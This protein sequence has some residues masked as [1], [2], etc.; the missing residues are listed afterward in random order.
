MG[1]HPIRLPSFTTE[2]VQSLS[3]MYPNELILVDGVLKLVNSDGTKY[4]DISIYNILGANMID[5]SDADMYEYNDGDYHILGVYKNMKKGDIVSY[6]N[7]YYIIKDIDIDLD[8]MYLGKIDFNVGSNSNRRIFST[9]KFNS[10][11]NT[12]DGYRYSSTAYEHD[13]KIGDIVIDTNI[14]ETPVLMIC[15]NST[16][17]DETSE[18]IGLYSPLTTANQVVEMF[19]KQ[20]YYG[21]TN[22]IPTDER[23]FTLDR[24]GA[25][26]LTDEAKSDETLTEII[27]PYKYNGNLISSIGSFEGN[28]IV[29]KMVLPNNIYRAM[30]FANCT[31][32]SSINIDGFN[33][34][35][36]AISLFENCKLS[37][38][39]IPD[40]IWAISDR[41]FY[42]CKRMYS[43]TLPNGLS[44]IGESA[45][46]NC[47]NLSYITIPSS[48]K[49]I[50]PNAF[51]GCTDLTIFCE[52]G[53]YVEKYAIE[54]GIPYDLDL[55]REDTCIERLQ[56]YGDASII[57]SPDSYFVFGEPDEE[58][59]TIA[60]TSL[61]LEGCMYG[62]NN[63]DIDMILNGEK[64]LKIVVPYQYNGYT[65]TQL[66]LYLSDG[67]DSGDEG[68]WDNNYNISNIIIPNTV[69]KIQ[70]NAFNNNSNLRNITL[71]DSI[72]EI[73]EYAFAYCS[74]LNSV[75][76]SKNITSLSAGLFYE[77]KSIRL[78]KIPE[79]VESISYDTFGEWSREETSKIIIPDSVTTIDWD[80]V[81]IDDGDINKNVI[82]VCNQGSY[83][84]TYAK[85]KRVKYLYNEISLEEF[86]SKN[87]ELFERLKYY[88]DASIVP[89]PDTYFSFGDP[90]YKN[91]SIYI[92]G[93]SSEVMES[94]EAI[95]EE[96]IIPYKYTFEG[97]DFLV[98]EVSLSWSNC[99]EDD[100]VIGYYSNE[101]I[102]KVI[103]PST[104][105]KISENAFNN[106]IN[107]E[108]INIPDSVIEIGECAFECCSNLKHIKLSKN[109]TFISR[110]LFG[111]CSSIRYLEIPEGV[112][113]INDSAFCEW[114]R[115]EICK[116]VIP[117]SVTEIG[118]YLVDID[119]GVINENVIFV[120]NQGSYAETYAKE[121]GIKYLYDTVEPKEFIIRVIP[122]ETG[123]GVD[124][125]FEEVSHAVRNNMNIIIKD[126]YITVG[127]FS[128][129]YNRIVPDDP[130]SIELITS[131]DS[132]II[133]IHINE[134]NAVD[135]ETNQI[136]A[137]CGLITESKVIVDAVNEV[138]T[139]VDEV[140]LTNERLKYYGDIKIP[141]N[142]TMLEI[143]P[144]FIDDNGCVDFSMYDWDY[145]IE[146]YPDFVSAFTESEI[147]IIPYRAEN[148]SGDIV[149]IKSICVYTE[150]EGFE[151][152]KTIQ[153]ILPNTIEC[154]G[155][156]AFATFYS[157]EFINIPN[158]VQKIEG[159]AFAN[160]MI[161]NIDIPSHTILE[162]D[163]LAYTMIDRFTLPSGY[164]N[165]YDDEPELITLGGQYIG[166][167]IRTAI[168]PSFIQRIGF[169]CSPFEF[170][171]DL[172]YIYIEDGVSRIDYLVEY[173]ENE[174]RVRIPSSVTE[175][176]NLFEIEANN[177]NGEFDQEIE[178]LKSLT[179]LVV[180]QGSYAETY[181]KEHGI[182]YVYDIVEVNR[183]TINIIGSDDNGNMIPDK[184]Y[185]DIRNAIETKKE[186]LLH[187]TDGA[188]SRTIIATDSIA[189]TDT[190]FIVFSDGTN[191]ITAVIDANNNLRVESKRVL[192]TD[193]I[194]DI[195]STEEFEN[196]VN[197]CLENTFSLH[198]YCNDIEIYEHS[199][200][201]NNNYSSEYVS[202]RND[203]E[204]KKCFFWIDIH[205]ALTSSGVKWQFDYVCDFD[206]SKIFILNATYGLKA[207]IQFL[208]ESQSV[209]ETKYLVS[210]N[211]NII[212]ISGKDSTK[213]EDIRYIKI[214][215]IYLE[216]ATANAPKEYRFSNFRV[217]D[218]TEYNLNIALPDNIESVVSSSNP[219]YGKKYV[220]CGDSITASGFS[221]ITDE[222]GLTGKDSPKMYD[223][224]M[225]MFKTYPWLIA[226]RNGMVL[227]NEAI[228][229][230]TMAMNPSSSNNKEYAFSYSETSTDESGATTTVYG[231]YTKIPKDADYITLN[232]GLN[233]CASFSATTLGTI[234]DSTNETFYGAWNIVLDYIIKNHPTAKIGIII[235]TI[236]MEDEYRN[237]IIQVAK[238]WKIPYLDLLE[239]D[240]GQIID[241]SSDNEDTVDNRRELFLFNSTY[242]NSAHHPTL[243]GQQWLSIP[244]E[245]FLKNMTAPADNISSDILDII[246]EIE[247]SKADKVQVQE[248]ED[249]LGTV[250][251]LLE[252]R[253]DYGIVLDNN[254]DV[255]L[256][257][258][259]R[260]YKATNGLLSYA[261]GEVVSGGR[262]IS[263]FIEVGYG[264]V[265]MDAIQV[266]N[267]TYATV[268][269]YDAEKSFVKSERLGSFNT[270]TIL[271][272]NNYKYIRYMSDN[273]YYHYRKYIPKNDQMHWSDN[274]GKSVAI[275][276][277]SFGTIEL[278]KEAYN[279]WGKKLGL[280]I[281][282]YAV[283]GA[284][285][286]KTSEITNSIQNQV[287]KAC[288]EDNP[289]YDIYVLWA[290]SNDLFNIENGG[291]I[292]DYLDYT[293]IDNYDTSKLNTQCGGIN[294]CIKKI[295]EKNPSAKIVLF[296]SIRV[297]NNGEKG[298]NIDYTGDNG[299][300]KLVEKQIKCCER[301]GIPYL[302]QY[303]DFQINLFTKDV[304][305]QEDDC[306]LTNAGYNAIKNMQVN[307]L[308]SC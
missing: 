18:S 136:G 274:Y 191:S 289:V 246:D 208:D 206:K 236:W 126:D 35:Y 178:I 77:C 130:A 180:S 249:E 107:L 123:I 129:L 150:S 215:S 240:I 27:I 64:E 271:P 72:I 61:S 124:K 24:Y 101:K 133:E 253:L 92:S 102:K 275:F 115:E 214:N 182:K 261:T 190:L 171:S 134:D 181:A 69:R 192:S 151:N 103:I 219:L 37:A 144:C 65:V 23:Y 287:D 116:I 99:D 111:G 79:C 12:S 153:I 220:A 98:T 49:E 230:S 183:L 238:K 302:N 4:S 218:Y 8:T 307:F 122:T 119:D 250:N 252:G 54:N 174:L 60:I 244:I 45:F 56:Y 75:E 39:S 52:R 13:Q 173:F 63:P 179:T 292:G 86:S 41:A 93:L 229:G 29:K 82:F 161:K 20:K 281:D 185:D 127:K 248:I 91:N 224:E 16:I 30:S 202:M 146:D 78:L 277:G 139:N 295:Y 257:G 141:S 188:Y 262:N 239:T 104:V 304:L 43:V 293:E 225:N 58:N 270:I 31:S 303:K 143:P 62:N 222:N 142:A 273:Y 282:S 298:Y 87:T 205:K 28:T 22:I 176:R 294:Y 50:G 88:G 114:S 306:H 67:Y 80:A 297:F 85:E 149:D 231:R 265:L 308:A 47:I 38:I 170:C 203:L 100:N 272:S 279:F 300:N 226:K 266:A 201:V 187:M 105:T 175:I 36:I 283:G 242:G 11:E 44:N 26:V 145:I 299:L 255:S 267:A 213:L 9:D 131:T 296:T 184:S 81:I 17:N 172:Q 51:A 237:A 97:T 210:N 140:S 228:S 32:L 15:Y 66:G 89:S 21:D 109:I 278:A 76:L 46:E 83:A 121:H 90:D 286:I 42:N 125:T 117:D 34:G 285:F 166:T 280:I 68:Y 209:L 241:K 157:L 193:D 155:Y 195:V 137:S 147:L 200:A 290:S 33:S 165:T 160:T 7:E 167:P 232:F 247:T 106:T 269:Y 71:P 204:E 10:K 212:S 138:K 305:V 159:L 2:E 57:P 217:Y 40:S 84:E 1:R 198:N 276:S 235:N 3:F 164:N 301:Y 74:N 177:E 227:V 120:F 59:K 223:A 189:H 113:T 168:I 128:V 110:N 233:D 158:S 152:N 234:D 196:K 132:A 264:V 258:S 94:G 260:E 95:S 25:L 108:E 207:Q 19:E 156:A 6:R 211:K 55:T 284:G 291:S 5:I 135:I 216:A 48:V 169:E 162:N 221:S 288:A 263:D 148:K 73:G 254:T 194:L 112:T 96:I 256:S 268:C 14:S 154:I 186:I 259:I 197:E 243:L 53:S 199:K 251:N 245:N 118:E 70:E 163:A